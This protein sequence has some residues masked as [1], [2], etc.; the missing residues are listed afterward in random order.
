MDPKTVKRHAA[1]APD[2]HVALCES[3][4]RTHDAFANA[5]AT[6]ISGVKIKFPV[7][8]RDTS[9]IRFPNFPLRRSV[10]QKMQTVLLVAA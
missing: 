1:G 6:A 8:Q 9:K 10:L 3:G 7:H 5:A 2:S 4:I